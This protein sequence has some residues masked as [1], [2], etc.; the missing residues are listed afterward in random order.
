MLSCS[1]LLY[2]V[3][4]CK[5]ALVTFDSLRPINCSPP[6][7]LSTGISRQEYWSRFPCLP[8]GHL[9]DQGLN[10]C[11]F[12]LLHWEV[13]SLP[14]AP[15]GK[16]IVQCTTVCLISSPVA[17][18]LNCFQRVFSISVHPQLQDFLC[19]CPSEKTSLLAIRRC[20]LL[21]DTCPH[22]SMWEGDGRC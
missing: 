6:S 15:P 18:H 11:L 4:A 21:L 16:P 1:I 14:L 9:P 13:S 7:T 12:C 2:S 19:T 10:P 20:D 22:H 17:G 5:V 3:P 8:P